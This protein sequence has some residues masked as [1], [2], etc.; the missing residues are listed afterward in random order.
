MHKAVGT[1]AALGWPIAIAGAIGYV[2]TGWHAVGLPPYSLGYVSVPAT[3]GIACTSI[4]FAPLGVRLGH[5]LP[6]GTL[7]KIFALFLYVTAFRMLWG[8][9]TQ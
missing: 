3:L 5:S 6:V 7:R 9:L 4:F 8:I 1:S 2:L